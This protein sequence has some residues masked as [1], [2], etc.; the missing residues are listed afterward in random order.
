MSK[1]LTPFESKNYGGQKKVLAIYSLR[2]LSNLYWSFPEFKSFLDEACW[3]NINVILT[4]FIRCTNILSQMDD[5]LSSV[6]YSYAFI[7]NYL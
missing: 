1:K 6:L 7:K 5:Q 2:L 4:F 3:E